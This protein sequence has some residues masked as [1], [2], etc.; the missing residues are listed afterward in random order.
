MPNLEAVI[1]DV[2]GTLVDTSDY[3]T[4]AY[5]HA[6]EQHGLP[7]RTREE[8]ASQI[9]KKLE[10][11]YAFLAPGAQHEL[12]IATHRAFQAENISLVKPF[13]YTEQLLEGLSSRGIHKA[14]FTSR[15]NVGPSL[16]VAGV[17]PE[18]FDIIIDGAMVT[19]GKPD[20]EGLYTILNYLDKRASSVMMVGDA[21]VDIL[22]GKNA[23][24]ATTVG[25]THGFGTREELESAIPDHI[26]DSLGFLL[27]IIDNINV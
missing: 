7:Y 17:N 24:V 4:H 16:E 10:D 12:L 19:K 21:A 23:G 8:I 6:L 15:K 11:C 25:V 27:P 13:N 22:A 3:I 18:E 1:F 5:Q 2:D 9:G 20:P 26:I 14:L